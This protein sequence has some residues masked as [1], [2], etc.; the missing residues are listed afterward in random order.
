M[1]SHPTPSRSCWIRRIVSSLPDI[2]FWLALTFSAH[3]HH[4]V[5]LNWFDGLKSD[6]SCSFC[7]MT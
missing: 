6:A 5:A 4:K 2:N 3:P 7:R 1:T